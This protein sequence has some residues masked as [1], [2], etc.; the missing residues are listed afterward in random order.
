MVNV[1][2]ANAYTE[3]YEILKYLNKDDYQKIPREF[4]EV[5]KENRNL[6]YEYKMNDEIDLEKQ[7]MLIETKAILLNIFRDFIATS[8][9]REKI[10]KWQNEDR[11]LIEK[12]KREKYNINVFENENILKYESK[13]NEIDK[14]NNQLIKYEKSMFKRIINKIKNF[15]GRRDKNN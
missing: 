9:Q 1:K 14:D 5:I 15:F 10:K 2:Y 7:P 13:N 3:V 4:L 11:E 8:E 6:D 12:K